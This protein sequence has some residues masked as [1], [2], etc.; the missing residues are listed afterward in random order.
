MDFQT[1][2]KN[3]RLAKLMNSF[4]DYKEGSATE[5]YKQH[6]AHAEEIAEK[7]K[8][9]LERENAPADRAEKIDY[10]LG[11][12]KQ[13]KLE[14]LNSLYTNRASCP[15]VM[16]SGPAN[17]PVRKKE[18]QISREEALF[19]EDPE[20]LVEKIKDIGNNAGTIYSDDKNAVERIK[21]KIETLKNCPDPWGSNS[22]EIRRLKERLLELAPEEF[23]EQQA[24]ISI[25]G[26]KT[27]A[28]I[29]ALWGNGKIH[30]S[31]ERWYFDLVP[32]VFT[33]GKRKYQEWLNFEVDEMGE[34]RLQYNLDTHKTDAF[35]LTDDRK[36]ALIVGRISGSGNKAVIYQHLKNL[37]PVVQE[38]K[39]A[40]IEAEQNGQTVTI[41]GEEA[42]VKR[43]K[44]DM[45]LQLI[46]NGKPEDKTREIL[47]ANGFRWAPSTSAWQ[48]L[49][50]DNAEWALKRICDKTKNSTQSA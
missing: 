7:A 4:N 27:Y 34:N 48:R 42:E 33:D 37:S 3:A 43:N 35:P 18:R 49:L 46:F 26:A 28:E 11:V 21:A 2:E 39:A 45:R 16:I 32:L 17:F 10:L 29:V 25:N 13:K 50:N 24:N 12:Y 15:S 41:N 40:T 1:L 30:Q 19:N 5:E 8:A 44:E 23:A 36:Y 22:T 14:W 38:R 47:K 31:N 20:Y 9:K 6:C